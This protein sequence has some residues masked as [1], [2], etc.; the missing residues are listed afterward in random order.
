MFQL[1]LMI[2]FSFSGITG[3][4]L[5]I[6]L[7]M[8]LF[9]IFFYVFYKKNAVLEEI[10]AKERRSS[11]ISN[12]EKLP[13]NVADAISKGELIMGMKEEEVIASI[14]TP[15]RRK[16][17]SMEPSRSEVFIY[18]GLYIHLHAGIVQKWKYH[19]K[20]LGL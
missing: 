18:S 2:S 5:I 19:K 13:E 6:Y 15:K 4:Q 10:K 14:G 12:H 1:P 20:L 7:G 9:F 16:I 3:N 11:Y 17:L 8:T